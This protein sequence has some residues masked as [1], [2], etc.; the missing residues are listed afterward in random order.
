M[1]ILASL[2]TVRMEVF[3]NASL[4]IKSTYKCKGQ[5]VNEEEEST[6]PT[7]ELQ[8]KLL[9]DSETLAKR[10][11]LS[12]EVISGVPIGGGEPLIE[13]RV[14]LPLVDGGQGRDAVRTLTPTGRC[15]A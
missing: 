11:E 3:L 13:N 14:V 2:G 4:D 15:A 1:S 10:S 9:R 12:Q 8:V 5:C 7:Y 6:T